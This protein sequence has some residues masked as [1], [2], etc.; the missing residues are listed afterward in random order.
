MVLAKPSTNLRLADVLSS[1]YQALSGDTNPLGLSPVKKAAVLV[2]DGLGAHNL[3][4]R[5]GH[6]RWLHQAWGSRS[7]VADSGF[8]STTATAL[9]SLTTGVGAGLHGIVG[10]TVRDP[11]SGAMINHLKDWSPWV[12][13]A[14][15]QRQPTIFE[16]AG[17]SGI[18]SLALGESRFTGTDFT[19]A[20]WRGANFRGVRS[21]AEQGQAMREFFD[22]HDRAL[23]YLYWPALDRTGHSQ[24]V[25]S[26]AWTHRLEELDADVSALSRL[27]RGDEG[28]VVTAD[29]GMVD[30]PHE[31]KLILQEDSPLLTNVA[32]WGGEPR[33][34]QLYVD[35]PDAV[36]DV[37]ARWAESL[38]KT[39]RVMTRADVQDSGLLGPVADGVL[40]RLGDVTIAFLDS[41]VAHRQS[42]ASA[43][44]MAMVGQHGSL[45]AVEREIPVIPV[46]A[47]A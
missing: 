3:R 34:P 35:S 38:G 6:A 14:T 46:G 41:R 42:V 23:V 44:S 8:P 21:L 28:L 17:A 27:L 12:D 7:L 29:H 22:A 30:V 40:E 33:V 11:A 26:E 15:W 1:C 20:V 10:Y 31:H 43:A 37:H 2:V 45:T 47:W 24:G 19:K 39:A 25:D 4:A 32:A 9:A 36:A 5:K 18:P 16:R 13:P